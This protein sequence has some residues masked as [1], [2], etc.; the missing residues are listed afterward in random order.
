MKKVLVL[1]T[2]SALLSSCSL[3]TRTGTATFEADAET[4]RAVGELVRV[5]LSEK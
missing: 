2:L 4:V 1:A 3:D 5:V